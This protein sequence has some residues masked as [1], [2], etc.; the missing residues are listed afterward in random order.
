MITFK[1]VL[2]LEFN[3]NGRILHHYDM[4]FFI[5]TILYEVVIV[6]YKKVCV[7]YGRK[8]EDKKFT[9]IDLTVDESTIKLDTNYNE[10]LKEAK[11][12]AATIANQVQKLEPTLS[13]LP[14]GDEIRRIVLA[15]I[16]ADI[17]VANRRFTQ[18][19]INDPELIIA[20]SGLTTMTYIA[21]KSGIPTEEIN[22]IMDRYPQLKEVTI[23]FKYNEL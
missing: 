15:E 2:H 20:M 21:D 19:G 10:A 14:S 16:E 8:V 3:S 13:K 1:D 7:G 17:E 12:I 22:R 4:S 9:I 6:G 23:S 11:T 18:Y 5:G